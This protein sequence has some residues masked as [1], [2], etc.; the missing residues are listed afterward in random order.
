MRRKDEEESFE[1]LELKRKYALA[2]A[3]MSK[4]HELDRKSES[5]AS[6]IASDRA[7]TRFCNLMDALKKRR[8]L[9]RKMDEE[10][11]SWRARAKLVAGA[12]Q[13]AAVRLPPETPQHA[14]RLQQ[15]VG[16]ALEEYFS[17]KIETP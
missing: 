16:L 2:K 3:N 5:I 13:L 4:Q 9:E 7:L 10:D 1:I 15:Q 17:Q 8:A 11:P 6:S 12:Q 14:V